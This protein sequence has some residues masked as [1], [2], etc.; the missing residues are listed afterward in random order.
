MTA[1]KSADEWEKL[2]K[3]ADADCSGTLD[4][5]E[6]RNLL[7]KGSSN[8]TDSQ[9]ADAFVF[10]DGPKGD[11]RITLDEFKKGLQSLQ[12]FIKK[13]TAMFKQY[14]CDNSGFLDK[15]ELRKILEAS[16]HKFTEDEVN[17]ILKKA[18]KS[19]DGKIS[20]DEFLEACT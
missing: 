4:V 1:K 20:F 9:I 14:D 3:E 18:D 11:R 17:D 19:G 15:N 5:Y 12:T 8:L 7:K 10:F 6:L 2:Y 16:S 13:L